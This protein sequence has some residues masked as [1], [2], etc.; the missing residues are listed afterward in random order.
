MQ[1]RKTNKMFKKI[2]VGSGLDTFSAA[3]STKKF[4]FEKVM[5]VQ[6]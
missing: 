1:N 4:K 2:K 3:S 5:I 6:T